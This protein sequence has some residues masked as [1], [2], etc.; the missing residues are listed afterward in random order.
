MFGPAEK[1][2]MTSC[3][4]ENTKRRA[5]EVSTSVFSNAFMTASVSVVP[6]RL[7]ASDRMNRTASYA[8]VATS[9]GISPHL[10]M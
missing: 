5:I 3:E 1:L 4:E 9:V 7:I 6:A 2:I 8:A 10:W